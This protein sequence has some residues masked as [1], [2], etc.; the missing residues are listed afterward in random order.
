[1]LIEI[2]I[3]ARTQHF[4]VAKRREE[5]SSKLHPE[6]GRTVGSQRLYQHHRRQAYSKLSILRLIIIAE[7]QAVLGWKEHSI[8]ALLTATIAKGR[9]IPLIK[10]RAPGEATRYYV[11]PLRSSKD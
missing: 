11:A 9:K 2:D 1:M 5:S 10:G 8:R 3:A 6:N 4:F 7:I